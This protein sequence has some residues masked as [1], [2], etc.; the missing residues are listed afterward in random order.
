MTSENPCRRL[1]GIEV[2]NAM[3]AELSARAAELS[4]ALGRRPKLA[5]VRVGERPDDIAYE[6]GAV[7]RCEGFG[8]ACTVYAFPETVTNEVFMEGFRAVNGDPEI[9]G[10]LVFR[11]LPEQIN[12]A[13]VK[14]AIDPVKD[15]D[16]MSS[17]NLAKLLSGETSG[18][19][20]CTPAAVVA[21]LKRYEVPLAGSRVTIVGRSLVVGKPLALLLLAE[22]ATV[23]VCHTRTRELAEECRRAD[24]LIAAA[25]KAKMLGEA[26]VRP[27]AVVVDVGINVGAD[28]RLCGDV[29]FESASRAAAAITPVP[30]G[31]GGVTSAILARNTIDAC[32]ARA[33]AGR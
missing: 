17:V 6:R 12:E 23:T 16:C 26:H 19:A 14:A 18:H 31:V 24:I 4:A 22:H 25:G 20:P 33:D 30:G 5:V 28:G 10:V 7:K 29:D 32:A 21:L 1:T 27:G 8:L 2:T 15:V 11:P 9:D 3:K 13:A